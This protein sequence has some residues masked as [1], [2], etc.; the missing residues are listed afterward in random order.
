MICNANE[1]T[2]QNIQDCHLVVWG[3]PNSNSFMRKIL[4]NASLGGVMT[5]NDQV[6]RI[7]GQHGPSARSVPVLC[8]SNPLNLSRYVF[9]NSGLTFREVHD[10]TNSLQNPKLP[11][12]AILDIAEP[13]RIEFEPVSLPNYSLRDLLSRALRFAIRD[14]FND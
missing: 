14:S 8:Y 1:V 10:K 13:P 2:E 6:V 4:S 9:V 3:T 7:G 11:D 12:W 5:W